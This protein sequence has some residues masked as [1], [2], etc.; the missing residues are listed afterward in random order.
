MTTAIRAVTLPGE[1]TRCH[2]PE[3]GG[4]MYTKP[5]VERFGTVRELTLI[6]LLGTGDTLPFLGSTG[7]CIFN[8]SSSGS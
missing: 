3:G 7:T 5:T 4:I 6:G 2:T 1:G 8:C